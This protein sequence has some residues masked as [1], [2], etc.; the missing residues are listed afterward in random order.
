LFEYLGKLQAGFCSKDIILG[1]FKNINSYKNFIFDQ[2]D[3]QRKL[4]RI[5]HLMLEK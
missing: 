5:K 4:E 3:Y 2:A 1:Q